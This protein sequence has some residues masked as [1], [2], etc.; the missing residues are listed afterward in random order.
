[1]R[2]LSHDPRW[3]LWL[4]I[5][6]D[7]AGLHPAWCSARLKVKG[8]GHG[9][10]GER[11]K[12]PCHL[13]PPGPVV[14]VGSDIPLLRPHHV[15]HAFRLLGRYDLVFGPAGDGGFWLAGARR[16][17]PLPRSLYRGVRW[18]TSHALA[19]TLET[20]PSRVSVALADTLDDVDD[21]AGYRRYVS[22][23]A[24]SPGI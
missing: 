23:N 16:L 17:R 10:L 1:M 21:A 14:L 9:D 11:M 18:S 3:T 8:Q 2:R 15:W 22:R 20:I 19:D 4:F 13:L 7:N 12:R 24:T 5:T 6:P